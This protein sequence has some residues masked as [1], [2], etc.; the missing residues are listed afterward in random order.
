[1]GSGGHPPAQAQVI[2]DT[3]RMNND[4]KGD[5]SKTTKTLKVYAE[6][7]GLEIDNETCWVLYTWRKGGGEVNTNPTQPYPQ[8]NLQPQHLSQPLLWP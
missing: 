6:I 1:M 8:P 3:K 7:L 4:K 5:E 2:K